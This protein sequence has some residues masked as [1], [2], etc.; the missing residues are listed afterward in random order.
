MLRQTLMGSPS[1]RTDLP[2]RTD[3]CKD[4]NILCDRERDSEYL[5]I[6]MLTFQQRLVLESVKCRE[7][8]NYG[9]ANTALRLTGRAWLIAELCFQQ[10][11]AGSSQKS[12]RLMIPMVTTS[13]CARGRP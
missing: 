6:P 13:V 10:H 12:A 9:A 3:A 7:D 1:Q 5:Q 11:T 2:D 4:H 8:M